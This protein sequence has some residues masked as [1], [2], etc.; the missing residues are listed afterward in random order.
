[1]FMLSTDAAFECCTELEFLDLKGCNQPTIT[2]AFLKFMPKLV[3]LCLA[4]CNQVCS[5]LS[6]SFPCTTSSDLCVFS[7]SYRTLRLCI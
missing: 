2:G 1:M 4:D 3:D 7:A 6:N 5:D